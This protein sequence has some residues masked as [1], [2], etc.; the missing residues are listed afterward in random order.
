VE[1]LIQLELSKGP[2]GV[3]VFYSHLRTETN[4]FSETVCS[5]IRKISNYGQDRLCGL[6]VRVPGYRYRGRG[7]IPGATRFSE[8]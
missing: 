7:S 1:T 5:L 4:P 8:R 2:N 6:V 3:G